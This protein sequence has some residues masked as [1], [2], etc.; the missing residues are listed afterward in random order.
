MIEHMSAAD[1]A[2]FIEV[3][4]DLDPLSVVRIREY[5]GQ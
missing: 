1:V 5:V 2:Y 4:A 3:A